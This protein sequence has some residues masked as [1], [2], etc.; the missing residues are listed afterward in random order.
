MPFSKDARRQKRQL[1]NLRTGPPAP[2]GNRLAVRHGGYA[3]IA[4][5]RL[6]ARQREVLDALSEDAPLR[7]ANGELPRHDSTQV[8][9]LAEVLCRLEDVNTYLAAHGYLDGKGG[10]RPAAELAGRMR[11]EASDYLDALGM[12]PRARVKLGLDL[13]LATAMGAE[14]DDRLDRMTEEE[15]DRYFEEAE[16]NRQSP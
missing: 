13:R 9:L 3:T 5:D 16:R 2:K 10:V 4:R 14:D 8:A 1:A 6:E 11:R 15:V 7:D 12:T